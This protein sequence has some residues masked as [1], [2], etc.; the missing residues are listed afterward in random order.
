MRRGLIWTVVAL[1]I[2]VPIAVLPHLDVVGGGLVPIAQALLPVGAL[3]VV[4]VAVIA[5]VVRAWLAATV[6]LVGTVLAVLP[7]LT[8]VAAVRECEASTPLTVLSFNAKFA[9]ADPSQLAGLVRSSGADVIVLLET[10]EALIDAVLNEQGLAS[11]LPHR[12]RQVSPYAVNG[13]VILSAFPLSKERDIPGSVFDQVTAVATLPD[14]SEVRLAAVHPPPPVGQPQ[15]W[16]DGVAAIGQWIEDAADPR[17]VVAGDF[18]ASFS[19]PVFRSL[20]TD[21]RTAAEAAGVIPWPT[22]PEEKVV[23]AFTAIDHVLARGAVPTSWDSADIEGSDHRAVIAT[24]MLCDNA[25][26]S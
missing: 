1:A 23:P 13:S 9:G 25:A 20:A 11:S 19:H 14:G 7:V 24:W 5:L 12:T 4:V 2:A 21:V 18:N 15:R 6:L 17:L 3:A 8:P 10:D 26:G 16:Y 22:W